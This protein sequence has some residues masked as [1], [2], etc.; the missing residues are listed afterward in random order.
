MKS[1]TFAEFFALPPGTIFGQVT[2][3]AHETTYGLYR[4]GDSW[5]DSEEC[6]QGMLIADILLDETDDSP[7]E[8]ATYR[9]GDVFPDHRFLVY[10]PD[11]L[12]RLAELIGRGPGWVA[13]QGEGKR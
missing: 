11:D 4:K 10:E 8:W 9:N 3:R 2:N 12:D 6:D 1:M 5:P 7:V 13:H